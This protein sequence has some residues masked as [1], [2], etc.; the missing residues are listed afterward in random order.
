MD[1]VFLRLR[2]SERVDLTS[3]LFLPARDEMMRTRVLCDKLNKEFKPNE[4]YKPVLDEILGIDTKE[5]RILQPFTI[6]FGNQTKIANGVFINHSFV[7][8]AAGGITIDSGVQI[9]PNV[10]ILTVNH[11]LYMR[12]ICIC[13]PV[14]IKENVWIGANSTIMP[15]VTVGK[16]AVIGACSLVL[17]DVLDNQVVAGSPAKVIKT[18]DSSLMN[19]KYNN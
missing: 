10:T 1:N 16:N 4:N 15:G 11:D 2:N 5:I 14:H 3:D 19:S 17:H 7:G 18:L 9:A 13:K 8:S 6:D 12:H